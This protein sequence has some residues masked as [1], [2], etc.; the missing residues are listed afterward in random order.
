LFKNGEKMR[1]EQ[2]F[3]VEERFK[4][5][6]FIKWV[7]G[8]SQLLQEIEKAISKMAVSNR[9]FTYIEPFVGGGAV[10]FWIL[11]KFSNI[12]KA[13]INDI[14]PDLTQAY[15]TVRDNV[16]ELI[17]VLEK[18]QS[19]YINLKSEELKKNFFLS[20]REEFNQK[21]LEKIRN[22]AL[23]IFLNRT[24]FNGLY[25]V[26]SKG[27][28]NVPFGKYSNPKICDRNTLL[29]DSYLLK[30]VEILNG[31]F[32]RTFEF[33]NKSTLF[34]FDPPYKPIS[35]TSSFTSYSKESFDDNE[36]VRLKKFCDKISIK[37]CAFILSNSDPRSAEPENCFFDNL[38]SNYEINRVFASR[39]INSNAE[40]RGKLTELLI[41]NYNHEKSMQLNRCT[42]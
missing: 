38:Y 39:M 12:K 14:N 29:S 10:L 23:F 5:K 15:E 27:L 8:K 19:E 26:N 28:F 42:G 33:T 3:Q 30:K 4:G 7:G 2:L 21:N 9:E 31:D 34:Y 40:K 11:N 36:Q 1:N 20:V 13:V 25:R 35:V 24:C 32:E 37:G 6:P 16:Y 41:T 18:I 22:A 17:E